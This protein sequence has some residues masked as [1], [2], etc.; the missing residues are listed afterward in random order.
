M[1]ATTRARATPTLAAVL[2]AVLL[3]ACGA[4][5]STPATTPPAEPTPPADTAARGADARPDR[6]ST[7][8]AT[9]LTERELDNL[10]V[11]RVEELL[12]GRVAGVQVI[13]TPDGDYSVRIRGTHTFT[14]NDEPLYVVDGMPLQGRRLGSALIGIPPQEI[15]RIEVLKDAGATAAY[16]SLGANGVIVI[17]TKRR[18]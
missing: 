14:G 6:Y 10:R 12:Q 16:G 5:R 9:T 7:G 15:S 18:R 2:A 1:T 17:T 13:R 3:A 8:A 11:A 4:A